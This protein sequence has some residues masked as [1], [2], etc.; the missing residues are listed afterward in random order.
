M[1][2]STRLLAVPWEYPKI[3]PMVWS[4]KPRRLNNRISHPRLQNACFSKAG[5]RFIPRCLRLQ[6][7]WVNWPEKIR[8]SNLAGNGIGVVVPT[9]TTYDSCLRILV[10]TSM[11]NR[12]EIVIP[13]LAPKNR[14]LITRFALILPAVLA[15]LLISFMMLSKTSSITRA[16]VVTSIPMPLLNCLMSAIHSPYIL[17]SSG[18]IDF[19]RPPL[20]LT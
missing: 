12:P 8:S 17:A 7:A 6:C 4:R 1:Q 10:R 13:R 14:K 20:Y 15:R 11:Y 3:R 5:A 19:S 9:S 2:C 16:S 18:G